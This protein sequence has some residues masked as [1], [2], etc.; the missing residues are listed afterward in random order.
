MNLLTDEAMAAKIESIKADFELIKTATMC[1][2]DNNCG[3]F[4]LP[5]GRQVEL[6]GLDVLIAL[7][8]SLGIEQLYQD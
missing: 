7:C 6:C 4:V 3:I 2:A 8:M 5:D 1:V